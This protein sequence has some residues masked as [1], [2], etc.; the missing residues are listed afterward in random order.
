MR[1]SRGQSDRTLQDEFE[2]ATQRS[3]S[4]LPRLRCLPMGP[5]ECRYSLLG[6]LEIG[7]PCL[8][9]R[10]LRRRARS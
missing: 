4:S 7:P 5:A 8:G 10:R 1:R 3:V 6:C 9:C 2:T